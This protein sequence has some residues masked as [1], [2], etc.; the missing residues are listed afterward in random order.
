MVTHHTIGPWKINHWQTGE[1]GLTC[2]EIKDGIT[3]F[4]APLITH[5]Y[6]NIVA[7]IDPMKHHLQGDHQGAHIAEIHDF[8][9][10]DGGKEAMANAR[11]IVASPD[12]L[13]GLIEIFE[14]VDTPQYLKSFVLKLIKKATDG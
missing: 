11:L 7:D 3:Y 2:L 4:S 13:A 5:E 14:E 6:F 1:N 8:K 12:M 10:Q 9:C